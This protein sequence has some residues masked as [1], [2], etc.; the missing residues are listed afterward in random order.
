MEW[1]S[2]TFIEQRF[3]T[4]KCCYNCKC[5]QIERG[6]HMT[7]GTTEMVK[8]Q[9]IEQVQRKDDVNNVDQEAKGL[10]I[11]ICNLVQTTQ[12]PAQVQDSD[13]DSTISYELPENVIGTI[14]FL[15]TDHLQPTLQTVKK[16]KTRQKD[17]L[18]NTQRSYEQTTK[19]MCFK[20]ES[21]KCKACTSKCR[22]INAHFRTVHMRKLKCKEC[23]KIY[24]TPYSL[25][26]HSYI[27]KNQQNHFSCKK[28]GQSFP[29]PYP[30][31]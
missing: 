3:K 5:K 25:K 7:N 15:D 27:H 29:S 30:Q 10:K 23:K 2:K 11:H 6:S 8:I 21:S 13:T 18:K 31:D 4:I 20:C 1:L 9:H 14:Y 28:C 17:K 26:Q 19:T 16:L 22:D 12:E 24:D